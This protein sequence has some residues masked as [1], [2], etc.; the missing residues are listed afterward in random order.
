MDTA[1]HNPI[2]TAVSV[3]VY[4]VFF[5]T[6]NKPQGAVGVIG[7]DGAAIRARL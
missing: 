6:P 4:N 7:I 3:E 5:R 1:V 2:Y